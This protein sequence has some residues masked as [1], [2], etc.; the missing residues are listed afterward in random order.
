MKSSRRTSWQRSGVEIVLVALIV[1]LV[2]AVS[3]KFYARA[4]LTQGKLYSL[5]PASVHL[6]KSVDGR[7]VAD[8]FLSRGIPE[9]M[10]AT[11]QQIKDLLSEYEARSSGHFHVRIV[12]PH[13]NPEVTKRA[14]DLGIPE[15]QVQVLSRDQLQ[16]KKVYIGLALLYEDKTEILPVIQDTSN[17]EYEI[18]S[19]I[20][21]LTQEEPARIGVVDLSRN[22]QFNP[23]QQQGSMFTTLKGALSKRFK[24]VNIDLEKELEIPEDVPTLL[25]L[26]PLGLSDEAKY[27][28]DQFVMRGGSLIAPCDAVM[29]GQGLQAFP[30]LPGIDTVLDKYGLK[31]NKQMVLDVSNSMATFSGGG[32]MLSLPYPMWVK[33]R[34]ENF[35]QEFPPVSQI[36]ALTLPWSGYFTVEDE[37][38]ES[39]TATRLF[40]T[41]KDAWLMKSP[42]DLNPQQDFRNLRLGAEKGQYALGYLLQGKLRSAFAD[43]GAPEIPEDATEERKPAL[44]KAL[45][46]ASFLAEGTEDARIVAIADGRFIEDNFL[47]NFPENVL[48]I[49]NIVDWLARNEALIGIRSRGVAARPI[50]ELVE[51]VKNAIKYG[52][53]IGLPVLIIL[54]GVLRWMLRLKRRAGYKQYYHEV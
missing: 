11:S 41:T 17:L 52:N 40:E 16:V 42:F 10:L 45:D 7:V 28:I 51:P 35:N 48:F 44:E 12:D 18:T 29:I 54:F 30:A 15:A 2:A 27:V 53:L 31:L 25:L 4:D 19:R 43:E 37:K 32:F 33:I 3:Q 13:D 22:F 46:P 49:E 47:R 34:P 26:N 14:N 8:L 39:V 36:E 23:Q 9:S 6:L 38:P 24:L 21:K 1:V 50:K 20:V 5:T